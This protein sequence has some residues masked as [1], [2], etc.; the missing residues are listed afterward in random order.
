MN[1]MSHVVTIRTQIKDLTAVE[2]A[3]RRLQ[4]AAPTHGNVQLYSG[5][6]TG[7]LVQLPG[8]RYPLVLDLNS[9]EIRYDNFAGAWK[10]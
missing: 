5:L 8:W 9:A 6:A 3:C 4:L 2:A 7:L 10:E 1:S